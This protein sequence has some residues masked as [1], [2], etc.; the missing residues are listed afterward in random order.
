MTNRDSTLTFELLQVQTNLVASA[1]SN[2][3]KWLAVSDL[4]ETKL[5]RLS[6]VRFFVHSFGVI[7]LIK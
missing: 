7:A 6:S 2:D 1:V 4:F 5:F 3:G